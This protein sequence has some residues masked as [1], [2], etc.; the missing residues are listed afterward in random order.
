MPTL[1]QENAYQPKALVLPGHAVSPSQISSH[2]VPN[3][4]LEDIIYQIPCVSC[5]LLASVCH[6]TVAMHLSFSY[7]TVFPLKWG[8]EMR[9]SKS[10]ASP[11][12]ACYLSPFFFCC[13]HVLVGLPILW[14]TQ[15]QKHLKN[16]VRIHVSSCFFFLAECSSLFFAPLHIIHCL[17]P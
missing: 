7:L 1:L 12:E 15:L 4:I 8:K 16:P 5:P 14:H 10:C 17:Y 6:G 11:V 9:Y 13:S 2:L 3:R